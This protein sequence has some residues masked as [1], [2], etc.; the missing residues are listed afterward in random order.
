MIFLMLLLIKVTLLCIDDQSVNCTF[1]K[2]ENI[3]LFMLFERDS[4]GQ[5]RLWNSVRILS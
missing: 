5:R 1:I 4:K 2:Y 3:R